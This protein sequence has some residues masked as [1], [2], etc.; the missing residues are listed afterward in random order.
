MIGLAELIFSI[1][2]TG[3]ATYGISTIVT[4][5]PGP[6]AIFDRFRESFLPTYDE[7]QESEP[8]PQTARPE[9]IHPTLL[10]IVPNENIFERTFKGTLHG[11]M[12][13]A[14]CLGLWLSFPL[15]LLPLAMGLITWQSFPLA[16]LAAY[17]FHR[18]LLGVIGDL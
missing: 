18:F 1:L 8:T 12:D 16:W 9:S 6:F 2:A 7:E 17:G 10:G 13:C 3:F 4:Q 15:M 14:I 11:V 5:E